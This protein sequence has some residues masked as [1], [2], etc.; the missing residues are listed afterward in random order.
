MGAKK[1][2]ALQKKHLTK[3]EKQKKELEE[4]HKANLDSD[5]L[6]NIPDWLVDD[7]AR[8]EWKRLLKEMTQSSMICNLVICTLSS[9]QLNY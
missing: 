9:A 1:P 8:V 2:L 7:V 3:T 5:Y 4:Q 6:N